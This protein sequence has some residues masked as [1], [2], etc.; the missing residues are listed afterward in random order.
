[1]GTTTKGEIVQ[2]L[3]TTSTTTRQ[4]EKHSSPR[5]GAQPQDPPPQNFVHTKCRTSLSGTGARSAW[6]A[7]RKTGHTDCRNGP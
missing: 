2:E 4:E 6:Q 3:V 5:E 7:G 1:M